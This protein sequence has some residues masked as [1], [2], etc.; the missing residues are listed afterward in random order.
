MSSGCRKD[1]SPAPKRRLACD[2][3]GGPLTPPPGHFP[4]RVLPRDPC[5]ARSSGIAPEPPVGVICPQGGWDS[6]VEG[7]QGRP[8]R[9][10]RVPLHA[11]PSR[12][13]SGVNE[14]CFPMTHEFLRCAH[15]LT[16]LGFS[17]AVH[18]FGNSEF[19]G[20]LHALDFICIPQKRYLRKI[21]SEIFA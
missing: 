13:Q 15:T 4:L 9:G 19:A 5:P 12:I 6:M 14:A 10:A 21:V 20:D 7:A 3:V 17:S 11:P 8:V 18:L 2:G 16:C 1:G